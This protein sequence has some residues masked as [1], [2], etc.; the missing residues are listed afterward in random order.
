M[1]M[2]LNYVSLKEAVSHLVSHSRI[3]IH[4]SAATPVAL[5]N[6]M[7]ERGGELFDIELVSISLQGAL[8][9]DRP[10]VLQS[11]RM[12]SLFVS[13]NIRK[14]VNGNCGD[15]VP[16][17]LSEIPKMFEQGILPLDAALVQVSPPDAHGYCSLGTSVDAA[18]SAVRSAGKVI[19]QVNPLMPRTHGDGQVHYSHFTA[20]V[21]NEQ[22]LPEINYATQLDVRSAKIGWHVASLIE[23]GATLINKL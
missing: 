23:D 14:W 15:Y 8:N 11:F 2:N 10:E 5:V 3:F 1:P 21:W 13:E 16:V 18:I 7:L 17:F 12:N 19:A 20:M 9:W 6:A 4:G 22:P